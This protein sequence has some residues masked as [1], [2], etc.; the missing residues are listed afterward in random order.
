MRLLLI[1]HPKPDVVEGTCY[2][3]TDVEPRADHLEELVA[4][5]RDRWLGG[6]HPRPTAVFSS[7]LTRC[8][9]VARALAADAWPRPQFDERIAE[10]NFGHW[11]GRPWSELPRDEIEAWRADIERWVPPGGESVRQMAD[12]ALSFARERLP[13]PGTDPDAL[14][15]LV[16][17]A[18]I[19]QALPRALRGDPMTGFHRTQVDYGSISTLAW[20]DGRFEVDGYNVAA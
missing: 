1:R 4:R 3:R 10:M 15:V 11:E 9:R 6:A 20:R 8:A 5:L 14:V 17:H 19:I 2:G 16:T 7:P 18:G 13:E 12:R